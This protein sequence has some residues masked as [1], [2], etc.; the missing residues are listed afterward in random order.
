MVKKL[1]LS[2][3][4][5]LSVTSEITEEDGVWVLTDSNFEEALSIQPDLLVEFYAPWCGHCKKIAP[6]YSKAAQKLKQNN[7]PIRIAK[8]DATVNTKI[9]SAN[10]VQGYPT[11]KYFMNKV[12]NEYTG[13]RTEDTIV[14]WV[15]KRNSPSLSVFSKLSELQSFL[16]LNKIVAVLFADQGSSEAAMFEGVSKLIDSVSFA[17]LSDPQGLTFYEISK[18]SVILLKQYDDKR[19]DFKG[20]LVQGEVIQF[21]NENRLPWVIPFG[22][23]AIDAIFKKQSSGLF[24]FTDDYSRYQSD[25]ETISQELK[26]VLVVT[27]ADLHHPDN[28]RLAEYLGIKANAQPASVIVD[29]RGELKKY[30]LQGEVTLENLRNF[31]KD[32]KN[33]KIEAYLK[34]EDV[35]SSPFDGNVRVLVGKNFEEVVFDKSKDVFV[36]FYAPWCGHCKSLAPEYE[37]LAAE[38]KGSNVVIAKMDATANEAKGVNIKG[39]PTLKFYPA[40]NKKAVDFDGDRNYEGMKKFVLEKA[41]A[42]QSE[43]QDENK[44]AE[45]RVEL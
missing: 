14:S 23:D 9:S 20:K 41:T 19:V 29:P 17:L 13:G 7:P 18:N 15:L 6:E 43:A 12:P 32:W 8:V 22:D 34:S 33:K 42:K 1:Y 39:F 11:L 31:V 26:G 25:L 35:P 37:K 38:F 21:I 28:N 5:L 3:L 30:R 4:L 27:Y 24:L 10:Q 16:N 44:N 45:G 2:L 40:G 36:E